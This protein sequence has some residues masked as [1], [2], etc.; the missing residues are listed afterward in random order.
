MNRDT[1]FI[2]ICV[3]LAVALF[4]RFLSGAG[5]ELL[6]SLYQI[7]M[8]FEKFPDFLQSIG[9]P[10]V[11]LLSDMLRRCFGIGAVIG[12]PRR[13]RGFVLSDD[14]FDVATES[15]VVPF[16]NLQELFVYFRLYVECFLSRI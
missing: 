7:V 5:Q 4:L 2:F 3:Y 15:I 11:P 9:C 1:I 14:F 6:E 12:G 8:T 10:L 16:Q 13:L